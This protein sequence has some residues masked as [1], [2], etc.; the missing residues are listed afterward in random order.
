[1]ADIDRSAIKD[2][3]RILADRKAAARAGRDEKIRAKFSPEVAEAV[4]YTL[5]HIEDESDA[6]VK[7]MMLYGVPYNPF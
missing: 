7:N 4:I 3:A 1:M 2:L 6:M 5:N